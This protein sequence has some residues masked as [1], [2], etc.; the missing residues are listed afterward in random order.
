MNVAI[1]TAYRRRSCG[2]LSCENWTKSTAIKD[3]T[4][5]TNMNDQLQKIADD[6][7]LKIVQELDKGNADLAF[8]ELAEALK[9]AYQLNY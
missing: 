7:W 8:D 2:V 5:T 3:S 9:L 6:A 1:G 4:T